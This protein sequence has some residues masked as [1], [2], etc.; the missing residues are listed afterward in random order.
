[1]TINPDFGLFDKE[2]REFF[3]ALDEMCR[4]EAGLWVLEAPATNVRQPKHCICLSYGF[5]RNTTSLLN[6]KDRFTQ[7]LRA[8]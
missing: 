6:E 5:N 2:H 4:V 8:N 7:K 1:M 3:D